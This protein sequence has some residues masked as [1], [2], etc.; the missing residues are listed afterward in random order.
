MG[1]RVRAFSGSVL[2]LAACAVLVWASAGRAAESA[3]NKQVLEWAGQRKGLCLHLG[4]GR[5]GSPGLTADLAA[6]GTM[7]VHGLAL[8]DA[9]LD[10]ARA[11]IQAR[12]LAGRAMAE[13]IPASPLPYLDNLANLVVVEDLDAL[14]AAGVGL[15]EVQRV[16][17]PGGSVCA[18][19]G[20]AWKQAVKP[21][22]AEM[23]EWTHPAHGPDNNWV[24]ADKIAGFPAG[25]RWQDGVPMNFNL[26]AACRAF[27]TAGGRCF[28]LSTTEEENLAP[29][30]HAKHR[31]EEYLTARDA[32]NGLPLWKVNCETTNEGN[33]LNHRNTAPL[34]ADGR[35][36]YAYK[37]DQVVGLDAATGQ[38]AVT[39]AVKHPTVRMALLGD[40]LVCAGWKDKEAKGLWDPWIIKSGEGAVEA[41][42]AATG[43]AKWSQPWSAQHML[44]ADGT[45]YLL[46]QSPAPQPPPKPA[47]PDAAKPQPPAG[48][49]PWQRIVALDLPSGQ[50]RWRLEHGKLA[51]EADLQFMAA[52][53]GILSVSSAKAK[54]VFI[55]ARE[56]GKTLWEI[57][58]CPSPW[59]PL[60]E[61]LLWNG[62]RKY[63]PRTGEVKGMLAAGVN[64]GGCT[65]SC[66]VG[67]G[68]YVTASRGCGYTDLQPN[69]GNR[70][71]R[72]AAVRGGC[73]EG[74]VPANG[75]FYTAQNFCRCAP[76]Q[77]SGFVAFGPAGTPLTVSDFE[78][79]RPIEKGPAGEADSAGPDL[80]GWTSFLGDAARS[81]FAK[82]KLPE[83]LSAVR[84]I[85]VAAPAQGPLADAWR[86]RLTSCISSPVVAGGQVVLALPDAGRVVALDAKTGD[87]AWSFQAGSRIDSPPTLYRG[88]CVFGSRDGWVYALRRTDGKLAWRTRAAPR[89]RRMVAFGQVESVWPAC[90]SV[91]AR[92]GVLYVT[93]GRTTESDGG[94][95][96]LALEPAGGQPKWAKQIGSGP[97]RVNDIPAW[98]DGRIAVNHMEFQ[99]GD[100]T[101]AKA[102]AKVKPVKSVGLEGLIDGTWARLGMRRSGAQA[103]GATVAEMLAW[104]D[105]TLFA[106][107]AQARNCY[108]MPAQAARTATRPAKEDCLWRLGM[109]PDQTAC[110]MAA[111]ENALLLGGTKYD[112]KAQTV[113]GFVMVISPE[114]GKKLAEI[115]LEAPPVYQGIAIADGGAYVALQNGKVVWLGSR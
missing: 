100:G 113:S 86:A 108:A 3:G 69:V 79:T 32:F 52:G 44:A 57:K 31:K 16:T 85:A 6:A 71:I 88:L 76:G 98:R 48:P 23:D 50:E 46:L 73:L 8:D 10:R 51:G 24:S 78:G 114:N 22:P 105:K 14:K 70:S 61:G 115:A 74:A 90:G 30:L 59:T 94:L 11:A 49:A 4:C 21:R 64:S 68:R 112:P 75:L 39:F 103:Y 25:L 19:Q 41:F 80:A 62:S 40:V 33:A 38:V 55:L 110:A 84:T 102:A 53:Q 65:P 34:V 82:T 2:A 96:M 106:Y 27:V 1:Q 18:L 104:N 28:T 107:D 43:K 45:V 42:D 67:N 37:K 77:V 72:Y 87:V 58:P 56:D 17:A 91:M 97:A 111:C 95:A 99:A 26:W 101:P 83:E 9:S 35:R 60:V 89:E 109:G 63:D 12:Q 20:G 92:D 7:L 66:I 29:T 5:E 13:K 93:A 81:S 36:V 54:T 47:K 15:D